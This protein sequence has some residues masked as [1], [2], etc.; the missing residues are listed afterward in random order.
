L[1][2]NL[3]NKLGL[4]ES[5]LIRLCPFFGLGFAPLWVHK[6]TS[7]KHV[8]HCWCVDVHFSTSTKCI[9]T[10]CA[11][12]MQEAWWNSTRIKKLGNATIS[13]CTLVKIQLHNQG[14]NPNTQYL[15][16]V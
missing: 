13:N 3:V 9:E 5:L 11:K 16:K 6:I 12:D 14:T 1:V 4:E 10:G 8:Y 7:Y 2:S 15:P